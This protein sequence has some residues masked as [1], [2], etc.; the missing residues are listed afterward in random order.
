MAGGHRPGG[1]RA[2]HHP[3]WPE[4]DAQT[5]RRV[6]SLLTGQPLED[7]DPAS[8][9]LDLYGLG[10]VATLDEWLEYSGLDYRAGVVRTPWP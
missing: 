8:E 10:T 9:E 3:D 4:R 1:Q 6:S 2:Y 5:Y 7:G